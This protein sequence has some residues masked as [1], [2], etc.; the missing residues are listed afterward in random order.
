[1][2]L[3]FM[4]KY[5]SLWWVKGRRVEAN[6]RD[7][8]WCIMFLRMWEAGI[9]AY[10]DVYGRKY[11]LK[12][13]SLTRETANHVIQSCVALLLT[14]KVCMQR[15][16]EYPVVPDRL[17]SRFNEYLFGFLRTDIRNQ[18]KFSAYGALRHLMHYDCQLFME[19]TTDLE[20]IDGLRGVPNKIEK[21]QAGL[22]KKPEWPQGDG[23]LEQLIKTSMEAVYDEFDAY[24]SEMKEVRTLDRL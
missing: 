13:N 15:Y 19:G 3:T 14:Y 9:H 22:A 20:G 7:A 21:V 5:A 2:Y 1:M 11:N 12:H 10:E 23:A 6:V 4:H 8:V 24:G 16:P 18:C 17:S